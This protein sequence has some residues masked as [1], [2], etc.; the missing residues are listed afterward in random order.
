M[1]LP[2]Y[3]SSHMARYHPYPRVGLSRW[4]IL[5]QNIEDNDANHS[6]EDRD[7]PEPNA[8]S[9]PGNEEQEENSLNLPEAVEVPEAGGGLR[10]RHRKLKTFIIVVLLFVARNLAF[11]A[12]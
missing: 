2:T 5:T 4:E 9:L 3:R 6:V 11:N 12:Q 1:R 10:V 7:T 8:P